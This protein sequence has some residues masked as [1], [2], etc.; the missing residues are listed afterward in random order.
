MILPDEPEYRRRV[1]RQGFAA[2]E[3]SKA[4]VARCKWHMGVRT[5]RRLDVQE[6]T[7]REA[8]IHAALRPPMQWASDRVR[9]EGDLRPSEADRDRQGW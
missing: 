9:L 2:V 4:T 8:L 1:Y 3:S 5:D 7:H 6:E